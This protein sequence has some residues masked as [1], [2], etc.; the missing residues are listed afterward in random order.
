MSHHPATR[1]L[2]V[3]AESDPV[4]RRQ[5]LDDVLAVGATYI[6]PHVDEMVVGIEGVAAFIER[7]LSVL[8]DARLVAIGEVD[9]H[10][11]VWRQ[12]WEIIR[13]GTRFRTG[14]FVGSLTDEGRIVRVDGFLD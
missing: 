5:C 2:S 9:T 8:P 14:E 7:F 12:R 13:G 10:H 11:Q 4:R 6:D 3:F 1:F